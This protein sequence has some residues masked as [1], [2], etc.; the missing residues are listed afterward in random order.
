[1]HT[2]PAV[3]IIMNCLD[4]AEDLPAALAGVR[5]QSFQD[6]EIIFWDNASTDP[7]PVVAQSFGQKLRYFRSEET[8]PLGAARN[9]ALREARGRYIAFLDCDDVWLE[10]KLEEQVALF[11]ENPRLGLVCTDTEIFVGARTLSRVFARTLPA[12]GR[13]FEELMQ[14][15]WI[16]MSSAML[17]A[18]ALHSL[19]HWF[20]ES[21][22]LCEEAELFYR[23]AHDWELDYVD[24]PLTRWRVHGAN[25]TFK[26]FGEFARETLYILDK[27]RRIYPYYAEKHGELVAL[28]TRRA[29]FQQG[30]ALWRDG[31]GAKAREVIAPYAGGSVKFRLF[32][33]ASYLPG[34]FFDILARLYFALP[35]WLRG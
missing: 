1:M 25:T 8:V 14:R 12:R 9:L 6:W 5:A 33:A 2:T 34:A 13:G 32:Q 22:E 10:E 18:Q 31:Q 17:R 16:S 3:S 19:D 28:L 29:A 15:Q 7:S 24:A 26:K 23:I 35:G 27:H 11:E 4:C 30:V 20:D 21:L